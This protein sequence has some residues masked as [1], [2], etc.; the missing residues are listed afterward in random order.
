MTI[1]NASGGSVCHVVAIGRVDRRLATLVCKL[2]E[3]E[4]L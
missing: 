2:A 1:N 4:P 3:E